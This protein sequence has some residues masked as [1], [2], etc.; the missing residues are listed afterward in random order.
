MRAHPPSA[1]TQ[2][3]PGTEFGLLGPSPTSARTQATATSA[4]ASASQRFHIC[5][6]EKR[7]GLRRRAPRRPGKLAR[8][9]QARSLRPST[10]GRPKSPASAPRALRSPWYGP[11]LRGHGAGRPQRALSGGWSSADRQ[12]RRK[13]DL[14]SPPLK[15]SPSPPACPPAPPHSPPPSAAEGP[16][17]PAPPPPAPCSGEPA[18]VLAPPN[19]SLRTAPSTAPLRPT[20]RAAEAEG[21]SRGALPQRGRGRG[22][23][24]PGGAAG[25]RPPGRAAAVARWAVPRGAREG[26]GLEP[27]GKDVPRPGKRSRP[28][29]LKGEA[30]GGRGDRAS[31]GRGCHGNRAAGHRE[32]GAGPGRPPGVGKSAVGSTVHCPG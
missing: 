12:P 29:R 1:Q 11:G 14:G 10:P 7:A 27:G 16:A 3:A 24:T 18:G 9:P 32:V 25:W 15:T 5:G 6:R 4:S 20:G 28:A 13:Y 19:P 31:R 21:A 2:A 22:N 26:P 8:V 30:Q 17:A 23:S